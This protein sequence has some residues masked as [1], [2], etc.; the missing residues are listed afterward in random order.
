MNH[1]HLLQ[2]TT[3]RQ[4]KCV[5]GFILRQASCGNATLPFPPTPSTSATT[6]SSHDFG[7]VFRTGGTGSLCRIGKTIRGFTA[8]HPSHAMNASKLQTGKQGGKGREVTLEIVLSTI[9][10]PPPSGAA[11][12]RLPGFT[13]EVFFFSFMP[14]A[15]SLC[16]PAA[17]L[18]SALISCYYKNTKNHCGENQ[19]HEPEA[20]TDAGGSCQKKPQ[21]HGW[22][23]GVPAPLPRNCCRLRSIVC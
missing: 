15:C 11:W 19:G 12:L 23:G 5:P 14:L 6:P 22:E 20:R 21:K 7:Y 13:P 9:R 2:G 1:A 10:P 17:S 8:T 4:Q 16:T 3:A 18:S